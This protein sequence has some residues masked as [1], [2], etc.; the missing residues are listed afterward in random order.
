MRILLLLVAV[1]VW[2]SLYNLHVAKCDVGARCLWGY[3]AAEGDHGRDAEC[4]GGEE[5]E[6]I[7][8]P[9][10]RGVHN[11]ERI[12]ASVASGTS[13][14]SS[15]Y[16]DGVMRCASWSYGVIGG[17]NTYLELEA[18]RSGFSPTEMR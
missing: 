13:A 8:Q 2:S 3:E 10:E 7:L 9:H 17:P 6:D 18:R 15:F 4:D 14:Q 12:E 16:L 5:A 1:I 11:C